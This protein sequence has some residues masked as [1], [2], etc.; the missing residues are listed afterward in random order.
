M[1]RIYLTFSLF[2]SLALT[3]NAQLLY[4][5]DIT[6]EVIFG[7]GNANGGWTT[8]DN[9]AVVEVGLRAKLRFDQDGNPQNIFNSNGDGTYTFQAGASTGDDTWVSPTTPVWNFEW[10]LYNK[11]SGFDLEDFRLFFTLDFDPGPGTDL[12][13]QFD[14]LSLPDPSTPL[15]PNFFWDH[16]F[17][18]LTTPNGDGTTASSRAEYASLLQTKDV[19]QNSWN[20]EFFNDAPFDVFDPNQAGVYTLTLTAVDN[21]TNI[22][23]G[24]TQIDVIVEPIPEPATVGALGLVGLTGFLL[25]KRRKTTKA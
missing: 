3:A 5:Q 6:P 21:T 20:Y 23:W 12:T 14:G 17:G 11:S 13:L 2:G 8:N 7:S 24:E 16:S 15:G 19:V 10:S 4:D 1:K 9:A 22:I 25:W 18:T